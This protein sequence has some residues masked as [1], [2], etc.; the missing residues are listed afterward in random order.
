[1]QPQEILIQSSSLGWITG[2]FKKIH[3]RE[4]IHLKERIQIALGLYSKTKKYTI[5]LL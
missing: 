2:D 5:L 1:M 4:G 3:L